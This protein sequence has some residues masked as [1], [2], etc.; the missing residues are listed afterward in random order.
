[1]AVRQRSVVTREGWYYLFILSFVILGSLL[2]NIQL[3]VG[4]S[5]VLA[6]AMI[7]NW[8]WTRAMMQR[9]VVRRP[10]AE[11][12][13]AGRFA[14]FP[15]EIANPRF[16]LSALA[17]MVHCQFQKSDEFRSGTPQAAWGARVL[18]WLGSRRV[19]TC[20]FIDAVHPGEVTTAKQSVKFR[21]RGR[22]LVGPVTVSTHFP[23]GLV[24]REWCDEEQ[25]PVFVGP[26]TGSLSQSWVEQML[27]LGWTEAQRGQTARSGEDFFSLRPYSA[28]DSI[29]WIHW[30]ASA[31]HRSLLVKQ[32]Q[33]SQSKA[34][35][36]VVDLGAYL[37]AGEASAAEVTEKILRILAT[38]SEVVWVRGLANVSLTLVADEEHE[39]QFPANEA[40][41][42]R[43]HRCLSLAPA[44][45]RPRATV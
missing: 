33:R 1:M 7:L 19:Q 42:C 35:S 37:P 5:A 9:L 39:I 43:W 11:T 27:G 8:R 24:K 20:T 13:W 36:L 21:E 14:A 15:C 12:L 22:Y 41:W 10:A 31:R 32:F 44:P 34:F 18:K 26:G 40:K 6:T 23:L 45:S 38:I 30:R 2:R 4:L 17:L 29:R 16:R 3:L 28:G 25:V